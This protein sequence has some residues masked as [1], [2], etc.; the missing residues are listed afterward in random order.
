MKLNLRHAV[1]ALA[2]AVAVL[3]APAIAAAQAGWDAQGNPIYD[4]NSPQ[5]T[6]A[7]N[8]RDNERQHGQNSQDERNRRHG[9]NTQNVAYNNGFQAGER[10]GQTDRN[11]GHS[12][13]PTYSSTYKNGTSGYNSSMGNKA[14]YRSAF[15]Q[16]FQAGY[17][18]GFNQRNRR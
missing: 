1:W 8:D 5:I 3:G 15:Q 17:A 12:N 14:A 13:R 2:L 4:K 11:S 16:G 7:P 18:Q 9:N 10:Y 6:P